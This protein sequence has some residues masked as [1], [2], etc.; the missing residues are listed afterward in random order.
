MAIG[1]LLR[2][3]GAALK[4]TAK[5]TGRTAMATG[6]TAGRLGMTG[7]VGLG[8]G[9]LGAGVGGMTGA[10]G[11]VKGT[12]VIGAAKEKVINAGKAVAAPVASIT[13]NL[14]SKK[15]LELLEVIAQNTDRTADNTDRANPPSAGGQAPPP[16]SEEQ[17]KSEFAQSKAISGLSKSIGGLSATT[18][19]LGVALAKFMAAGDKKD[20][21]TGPSKPQGD[22][23]KLA[24]SEALAAASEEQ[25]GTALDTAGKVGMGLLATSTAGA[26]AKPV[27]GAGKS[28]ADAIERKRYGVTKEEQEAGRKA[29]EKAKKEAAD[30]AKR[31]ALEKGGKKAALKQGA[32]TAAGFG[33]R[34]AARGALAA[35]GPVGMAAGAALTVAD[36][37]GVG[38]KATGYDDVIKDKAGE[39]FGKDSDERISEADA[40]K[41]EKMYTELENMK[42]LF[43]DSDI[44]QERKEGY[45]EALLKAA[46]SGNDVMFN[47]VKK[48][49]TSE[50]EGKEGT[51]DLE[52][53]TNSLNEQISAAATPKVTAA[54][55]Q[56]AESVETEV[57]NM[58]E[59]Q[60]Q[61]SKAAATPA[62]TPAPQAP[63][64]QQPQDTVATTITVDRKAKDSLSE[65]LRKMNNFIG[66]PMGY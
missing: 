54:P 52:K 46:D 60:M 41:K 47:V 26:V 13:D 16:K 66:I 1:A 49:F 36:L 20:D 39:M 15:E 63:A 59:T 34:L 9:I 50:I 23:T 31:E 53:V 12:G 11:A 17:I 42:N 62:P 44:S 14:S 24:D 56:V 57:T 45:A 51:L 37:V 48:E 55:T 61:A 38:L 7:A 29:A 10:I 18:V 3:G 4:S 65:E 43:T 64:P 22:I 2:L 33:A 19:G 30:K 8:G 28:A 21:Q 58:T 25:K 5:A 35:F 32:K 40:K 27:I 6:K